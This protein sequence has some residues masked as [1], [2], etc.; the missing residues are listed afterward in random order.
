MSAQTSPGGVAVDVSGNVYIADFNNH[1]I[2]FVPRTTGTYFAQ[3]MT[4]NYMYTIA[5][6]GIGIGGDGGIATSAQLRYPKKVR[7]DVVECVY[8]R[9]RQPPHSICGENDR[10][11]FRPIHD[12]EFHLYD[13]RQRHREFRRR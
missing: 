13:C 11:L 12:R 6:N 4:A 10:H 5:G 9:P 1:R 8:R 2:R 3:S 7:V